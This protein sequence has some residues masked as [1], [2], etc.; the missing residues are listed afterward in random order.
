MSIEICNES[1]N[2]RM[3]P[4]M[5]FATGCSHIELQA[6]EYDGLVSSIYLTVYKAQ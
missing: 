3:H 5:W 1:P 4:C 2:S 6:E